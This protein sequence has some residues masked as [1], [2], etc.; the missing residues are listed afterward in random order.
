[1]LNANEILCYESIKCKGDWQE[2]YKNIQNREIIDEEECRKVLNNCKRK[3]ITILD[4]NY[5]ENLKNVFRPPFVLF[6]EGDISLIEDYTKN[7]AIVGS[8]EPSKYSLES[9]DKI[10][11]EIGNEFNV[12][13]GLAIGTDAYAH[14]LSLK[15]KGK[16]IAVLGCG[17]DC[18][19]PLTNFELRQR[20]IKNGLL[21]SE[22][23]DGCE[24]K[25]ENFPIRNRIII[26]LC[27]SIMA[28]DV[29]EQS[30]TLC[31]A[32]LAVEYN[33]NL[34]SIPYP[35]CS[36]NLNNDLIKNGALL[37]ENGEDIRLAMEH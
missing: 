12:V 33:R 34:L 24:P 17:L 32:N 1:M 22:Y 3:F 10:L 2:I 15:N 26:G 25:P 31:S 18:K 28:F 27:K 5:P 14:E 20:I 37:I 6:Y 19:Y 13:S 23:P 4:N 30:G 35:I 7:L 36:S 8:R 11:S 16:T 9:M 29:R 21:L